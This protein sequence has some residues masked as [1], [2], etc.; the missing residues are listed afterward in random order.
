MSKKK[1]LSKVSALSNS[2]DELEEKLEPLFSKP[3]E[4][5]IGSLETLQQTKLQVLL[6]YLVNDLIFIYLKTKGIDPKTHPVVAELER[7][8]Q[9]FAKIKDAEEPEKSRTAVVDKAAA[10]RFIKHAISEARK[11][12]KAA[13][14]A[15]APSTTNE[16]GPSSNVPV[17][18]TGKM[19]ERERYLKNLA[20][21]SDSEEAVLEVIDGEDKSDTRKVP[22]RTDTQ[23]SLDSKRFQ[24]KRPRP[25]D[26]FGSFGEDSSETSTKEFKS[27]KQKKKSKKLRELAEAADSQANSDASSEPSTTKKRKTKTGRE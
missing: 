9:Y 14:E 3:L 12:P 6:P 1:L 24:N 21:E 27:K 17:K 4:E 19:K 10:A 22:D 23:A 8:R 13:S 16:A 20:E 5:T 25:M 15:A 18:V 7:V 2:L 11:N 26:P